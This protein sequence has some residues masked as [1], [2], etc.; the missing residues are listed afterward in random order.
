MTGIREK[1]SKVPYSVL[2]GAAAI[3]V[4]YATLALVLTW[5]ISDGIAAA[6]GGSASIFDTWWQTLIFV[7]DI[8]AGVVLV[9]SVAAKIAFA[10]NRQASVLERVFNKAVWA[11]A[12]GFF[13]ILFVFFAVGGNIAVN[14][15]SGT[16]N[17][18]LGINIWQ[19]VTDPALIDGET[20]K[21][22]FKSDFVEKDENGNTV[23]REDEAGISRPVYDDEAMLEYASDVSERIASEG[24]V[25]LWNDDVGGSPALPLA[26]GSKISLMGS[27]AC[28]WAHVGRGSGQ[29]G[30]NPKKGLVQAF[31][32]CGIA[33]NPKLD[34]EHRDIKNSDPDKYTW[35]NST[36]P[37]FD[38]VTELQEDKIRSYGDAAVMVISRNSGEGADPFWWFDL[39][40]TE[41]DY[42]TRLEGYKAR[43]AIDKIVL[44]INSS[45]A[46]SFKSIKN[47]DI[48][49]CVWIGMGGDTSYEQAANVLSGKIMPSGRLV[50]TFVSDIERSEPAFPRGYN[51]SNGYT[52]IGYD[53]SVVGLPAVTTAGTYND[54]Y[55]IYQE[56]IYVGYRY[57]E[58][59]YADSVTKE[60]SN[61]DSTAGSSDGGAWSYTEEVAF[62]FGY[63]MS[64]TTFE[65]SDYGVTENGD[66]YDVTVNVTNTGERDGKEVVQIYLQKPYTD[67]DVQNKV[68][69]AAVELVGF[70][71]VEVPAG[72][73]VTASV[74]V[75]KSSLKTYDSYGKGTY[76]L[77]AGDYY[78][79]TGKNSHDALNNILAA[80]GYTVSDGMDADGN[81]ALTYEINVAENDYET[82]SVS[83]NGTK[84]VNRFD[85]V[86]LNRY[87]GTEDQ[88]T[89]Y[90]TRNDWSTFP[91]SKTDLEMKGE[92]MIAD[93]Q[94]GTPVE[95]REGDVMPVYGTVTAESRLQ[96]YDMIGADYD[97]PRWENLLD[98]LTWEDQMRLLT[99]GF[100]MI[101]GAPNAGI[102]GGMAYDGPA[103]VGTMCYP[104]EV[105]MA[106]TFDIPLMGEL[107]KIFGT[108]AMHRN[109]LG[110][111]APGAN[112]HRTASGGRNWEYYSEDPF[113]S[114]KMLAAEVRGIQQSGVIVFTKH[115]VLND[116]ETTRTGVCVWANEQS[117]REIYLKPFETGVV[118]ADMNGIMTSFNRLGCTWSGR[119]KGLLTDVLRGEWGFTGVTQTDCVSDGLEYMINEHAVANGLLSGQNIWMSYG[120]LTVLDNYKDNPT[121]AIALREGVRRLIYLQANSFAMNGVGEGVYFVEIT[122][123]WETAIT[124]ATIAAL[125]LMIVTAL[126]TAFAFVY[127]WAKTYRTRKKEREDAR[128]ARIAAE[129]SGEGGNGPTS[130]PSELEAVR[131]QLETAQRNVFAMLTQLKKA[132]KNVGRLQ[133][134]GVAYKDTRE[135]KR[136]RRNVIIVAAA[137]GMA[138]CIVVGLLAGLLPK[139]VGSALPGDEQSTPGGTVTPQAHVCESVCPVCGL[140][141][142]MQCED[143][144]CRVKCGSG[145]EKHTLLEAENAEDLADGS[146]GTDFNREWVNLSDD[147]TLKFD[148][149]ASSTATLIL[150]MR[151]GEEESRLSDSYYIELNGEPFDTRAIVPS[152]ESGFV[153][154]NLGCVPVRYGENSVYL[155]HYDNTP[156][157]GIDSAKVMYSSATVNEVVHVCESACP[158]CGGCRDAECT[159]PACADKCG[160][161]ATQTTYKAKDHAVLGGCTVNPDGVVGGLSQNADKTISFTVTS[162][163]AQPAGLTVALTKSDNYVSVMPFSKFM[164]VEVNGEPLTTRAVISRNDVTNWAESFEIFLGCIR[165]ERGE[166]TILFTTTGS[167]GRNFDYIKLGTD[168]REAEIRC[169]AADA[170]LTAGD[171]SDMPKLNDDHRDILE[172]INGNKGATFS[173]SFRSGEEISRLMYIA[174]TKR[175][176]STAPVSEFLDITINGAKYVTPAIMPKNDANDW[177]TT[178]E[179]CLG[180]VDIRKGIN[181]VTFTVVSDDDGVGRN[182]GYIRFGTDAPD[183]YR[184]PD[185]YCTAGTYP[186][187][188]VGMP[189][190]YENPDFLGGINQNKGATIT[191]N[192]IAA[193]NCDKFFYAA[194]TQRNEVRRFSEF[195]SITVNGKP[196][197]TDADMLSNGSSWFTSQE[198]F[199]GSVHLNAGMNTITFTVVTDADIGRNFEYIR[200]E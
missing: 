36:P 131:G 200:F 53:E 187:G 69:K 99:Y 54:K 121:V 3:V 20:D 37:A 147:M 95:A 126:G 7:A 80:R 92:K 33:L 186:D 145:C 140:C 127:P 116:Q 1:L 143:E 51:P 163:K 32:D 98:Q 106:S 73:S 102:P 150:E 112:I 104:C 122:P 110:V 40:D 46:M 29:K 172:S 197:T 162:D 11:F 151:G 180:A 12:C 14:K 175:S 9:L 188:T 120:D 91:T 159:D 181:V 5:A 179:I 17:S 164:T 41:K 56:G 138:A 60:G 182:F 139:A 125:V 97:D 161:Y 72:E 84:I 88:H 10:S 86:D 75:P 13:V 71:K 96:L 118:E 66:A 152:S 132:E 192:V 62:P 154:V 67:Y 81:A 135:G 123:W 43:G 155:L 25:V 70:T 142:D 191:F 169:N 49:A 42:L 30:F 55:L 103:G 23:F 174:L 117:I 141:T 128:A 39:N 2:I 4:F 101:A 47:Y 82:Y 61:A 156:V 199:L 148:S 100:R 198:V 31:G 28:E 190:S 8:V 185:A 15:Y 196:Y 68:E 21:E 58:T 78:L 158:E 107:G 177:W 170:V 183:K 194:L 74:S 115:L 65:Y 193:E 44:L 189:N 146:F 119:H 27:S 178:S 19:R 93:M 52:Y 64:Y 90:M 105:L 160:D 173:L 76:I 144:A 59:R 77:E 35:Y 6:T 184:A 45:N 195:M 124:A 168:K 50:D 87:E 109:V 157:F 136:Y 137:I 129:T 153:Q 26:E 89:V 111:Y 167:E 171:N 16:I 113:L 22:Y 85:D 18:A 94:Y 108:E 165:L 34:A 83:E 38:A 63:G 166:N 79:S 134:E 176:D 24:S 133:E 130:A 57:Y 149:S 114:G 48:D